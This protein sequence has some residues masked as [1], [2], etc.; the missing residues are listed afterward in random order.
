MSESSHNTT[1]SCLFVCLFV[2][3]LRVCVCVCVYARACA[4]T[5]LLSSLLHFYQ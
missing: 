4:N 5:L 1:R 2:C 3:L